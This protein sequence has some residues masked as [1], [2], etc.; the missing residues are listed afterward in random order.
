M[1]CSARSVIHGVFGSS[2]GCLCSEL[3]QRLSYSLVFVTTPRAPRVRSSLSTLRLCVTRRFLLGISWKPHGH[4]KPVR[5]TLGPPRSHTCS[6]SGSPCLLVTSTRY[7]H[8]HLPSQGSL[9]HSR[10]PPP[11]WFDILRTHRRT[12]P[13]HPHCSLL[14]G[15]SSPSARIAGHS[16]PRRPGEIRF[17][18]ALPCMCTQS[19]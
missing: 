6:S 17:C 4:L 18:R 11:A 7:A 2:H 12:R 5:V 1:L 13:L 8:L 3:F 10:E 14:V 19:D 16:W 15:L 9:K